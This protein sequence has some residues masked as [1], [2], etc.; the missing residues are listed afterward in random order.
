[1]PQS[2]KT[3]A[4]RSGSRANGSPPTPGFMVGGEANAQ[5]AE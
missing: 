2:V 1:M 4:A 3:V 5:S